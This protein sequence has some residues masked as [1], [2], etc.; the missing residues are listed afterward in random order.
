[1]TFTPFVSRLP[2]TE[3]SP[4]ARDRSLGVRHTELMMVVKASPFREAPPTRKPSMLGCCPKN[5]THPS[6]KNGLGDRA[7]HQK[8]S[9]KPHT[10]KDIQVSETHNSLIFIAFFRLLLGAKTRQLQETQLGG[11][12]VVHRAT[13]LDA[14]G[15][16]DLKAQTDRTALG[17]HQRNS[18]RCKM[19][20]KKTAGAPRNRF[21]IS[22]KRWFWGRDPSV[23]VETC[24]QDAA[25]KGKMISG[26]FG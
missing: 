16:A 22:E 20:T 13:V 8:T 2:A 4:V 6:K 1:M 14:H 11:V 21:W 23:F 26:G 7:T 5:I 17:Q 25:F 18:Y 10:P 24:F 9:K 12:L 3:L 19:K 15:V